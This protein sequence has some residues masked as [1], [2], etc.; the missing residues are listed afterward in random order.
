MNSDPLVTALVLAGSRHG[1]GDPV[2]R[3]RQAAAKCL[4]TAGGVPMLH[5][6]VQ[7]LA[8]SPRIG[9]ILV[10]GED[11]KLLDRIPELAP[12][13]E[14]GRLQALT[15]APTLSGSVAAAFALGGPPMLV[16]TADHALLNRAMLEHFLG[17]A[18]RNTIDIAIALASATVISAAYPETRRTYIRFRDDGYS[19]ANLFLLRT[20]A[21]QR[22][23][24]FWRRIERDRKAPWRLARAFGPMLLA[25]YLLRL[26]TLQQAMRLVSRRLGIEVAAIA[27]PMAEASIDVDKPADLD[28]VESILARRELAGAA[29]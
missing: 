14:S 17:V 15:S 23:I 8:A 18:D 7:A 19:G 1:E 9:A 6:V 26:A 12:L 16:T 11:E 13:R 27:M 5:R 21:A 25:A 4:V 24:D 10:S 20:R 28:L 22:G 29:V 2:A 3:Y